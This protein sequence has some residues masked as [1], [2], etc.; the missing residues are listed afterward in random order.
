MSDVCILSIESIDYLLYDTYLQMTSNGSPAKPLC[1]VISLRSDFRKLLSAENRQ[2]S[3]VQ[4]MLTSA[5]LKICQ[6]PVL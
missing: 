4:S 6:G 3:W 1:E 5:Q 2:S